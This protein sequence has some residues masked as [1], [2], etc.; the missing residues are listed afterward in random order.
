MNNK[1]HN[2]LVLDP[3]YSNLSNNI[4]NVF[5]G[6]KYVIPSL[7]A[8]Y[9]Y[10]PSCR[11]FR[12]KRTNKPSF[13]MLKLVVK[14][15]NLYC[16]TIYKKSN[17]NL[18]KDEII[19]F[20]QYAEFVSDFIE[21]KNINII[22]V[23]N[24]T[25][26]NHSLVIDIAKKNK[27][28][29]IVTE[30]GLIRP[31]TT[32]VDFMGCNAN[33][34]IKNKKSWDIESKYIPVTKDKVK[35]NHENLFSRFIFLFFLI[36][37]KMELCFFRRKHKKYIHNDYSIFKYVITL[38]KLKCYNKK[39]G[40]IEFVK[41]SNK[42]N[43]F[44]VLQLEHDSQF[45]VHSDVIKNQDLITYFERVCE[46]NDRQLIIKSHPLDIKSLKIKSTTQVAYS[47]VKKISR[48]VDY[49][50]TVNS[51]AALLV[52]ETTTPL[53]LLGDSIFAHD[54]VAEKISLNDINEIISKNEPQQNISQ[55][56]NF[57][58]YI[59]NNYLLYGAGF[60]YDKVN[61]RQK[62]NQIMDIV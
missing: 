45:I 33:S 41:K 6:N 54:K 44:L 11:F 48:E 46:E 60:S 26:W 4:C 22:L 47:C 17:R 28:P 13:E 12:V 25:R 52:L 49:V 14:N 18:S 62:L 37:V 38:Y 1:E 50:F 19:Y 10:L 31:N 57:L 43:V 7:Y 23:H 35:F 2:F 39:N 8:F 56:E 16:D 59:K 51:S 34:R 53:Y 5:N 30:L 55:R 36:L 20:A 3:M 27:I 29:V 61:I 58:N 42:I 21:R 15:K 40:K 24:D 32:V 9:I